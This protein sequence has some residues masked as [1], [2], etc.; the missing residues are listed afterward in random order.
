MNLQN[1]LNWYNW[2]LYNDRFVVEKM[3]SEKFRAYHD[4]NHI[5]KLWT[6]YLEVGQNR[7]IYIDNKTATAII[8]HD[9]VYNPKSK[10]NEIDSADFML[11]TLFL[12]NKNDVY[13]AIVATANHFDTCHD[14][15]PFWVRQFLDLDLYE[16]GSDWSIFDKND[17]LIF[18][19]YAPFYSLKNIIEGRLSFFKGIS[20]KRIFRVFTEREDQAHKNIEQSIFDLE[21]LI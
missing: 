16:L 6:Y 1:P 13:D 20:D 8:F 10:T 19:E 4:I 9:V 11:K 12:N 17:K 18:K 5:C 3:Y 14:D 2:S 21:R 7:D 15:A